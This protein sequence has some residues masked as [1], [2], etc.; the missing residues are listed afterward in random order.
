M[1]VTDVNIMLLAKKFLIVLVNVS[2]FF[3]CDILTK[4]QIQ[5]RL[6]SEKANS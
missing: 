1:F 2:Q 3:P 4:F 5:L 6:D